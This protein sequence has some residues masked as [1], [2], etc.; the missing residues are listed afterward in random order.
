MPLS[1]NS[2]QETRTPPC[3]VSSQSERGQSGNRSEQRAAHLMERM[4]RLNRRVSQHDAHPVAVKAVEGFRD[5]LLFGAESSNACDNSIPVS[6]A[7]L[8]VQL[9]AL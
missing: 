4:G 3:F 2:D 9:P 7:W 8:V 6:L 1:R 5:N